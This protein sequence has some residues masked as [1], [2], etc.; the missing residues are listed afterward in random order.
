MDK[1][2]IKNEA[3]SYVEDDDI[4][5]RGLLNVERFKYFAKPDFLIEKE[6]WAH[7]F[8]ES[9]N[10]EYTDG[11]LAE[12]LYNAFATGFMRGYDVASLHN[13]GNSNILIP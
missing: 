3:T 4:T 5:D 9:L 11:E 1:E 2:E 13:N 10:I 8:I 6:R 12:M 7:D